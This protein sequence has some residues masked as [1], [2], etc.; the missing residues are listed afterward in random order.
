MFRSATEI[1]HLIVITE[2]DAIENMLDCYIIIV[3]I[4]GRL[5]N[6]QPDLK[7]ILT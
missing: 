3:Y 6:H 7:H 2:R 4:D 5:L 1:D